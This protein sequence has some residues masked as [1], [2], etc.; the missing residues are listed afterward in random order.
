MQGIFESLYGNHLWDLLDKR[1]KEMKLV[2]NGVILGGIH[3]IRHFSNAMMNEIVRVELHRKSRN[4]F[5]E[6]VLLT[7][8]HQER[9]FLGKKVMENVHTIENSYSIVH[10]LEQ[11]K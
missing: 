4:P 2:N 11:S 5:L 1:E 9:Y 7:Y 8:L 3:P 6:N 10:S